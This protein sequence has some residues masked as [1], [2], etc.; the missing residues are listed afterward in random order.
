MAIDYSKKTKEELIQIIEEQKKQLSSTKYG[1]YWDKEIE[2]ENVVLEC[3]T[4]IPYL[5][6]IED[7][8]IFKNEN[9]PNNFIIEGD[10]FHALTC[11][12]MINKN[13]I[14]I[15]YI[16][17]PYNTGNETF[18]Y[19][20]NYVNLEDSFRHSK[21]LSFI[22]K[23]LILARE[24]LNDFGLIFI[25]IDDNELPNLLLL[26][27]QIFSEKNLI[28]IL[29]RV[30]K[31]GGKSTDTI[32]KNHDYVLVYAKNIDLI[33]FGRAEKEDNAKLEKDEF[34]EERGMYRLNQCLDYDSLQYNESMDYEINIDGSYFYA[35]GSK[36]LWESRHNGNHKKIDWVWRWSKGLLEW[37]LKNGFVVIK[38]GK[39]KRIYTKTYTNCVISKNENGYF[40]KKTENTKAYDSLYFTNNLFSNDNA[41]KELDSF[42]LSKKFD[43]PKPSSLIKECL[44]MGNNKKAVVLDFFAGSGTTGQAVLELNKEDG[45]ERK[46][47]LVTNNENEIFDKITYPRISTV[48]TGKK[49]DGS[50]YNESL[51]AN[52]ICYNCDFI[53][54][55][56]NDDQSLYNLVEKCNELL[57][58]KE[59][60]FIKEFSN[61]YYYIYR[62]FNKRL[63]IYFEFYNDNIITEM[64][65]KVNDSNLENVVYIFS[66]DNYIDEYT[67]KKFP[68]SKIKPIPSKIY[69]IYKEIVEDIKRGF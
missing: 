39:R 58:I 31:K 52:L 30:I 41:K 21:W 64:A 62:S 44:K 60:T 69:E 18:V 7:K 42:C 29:P 17:P 1:L 36:E 48:I 23:R 16:D 34:F 8:C 28:S 20:D 55:N 53:S 40:V 65:K 61:N 9:Y 6:R 50:L 27:N 24:L 63:F 37:G 38:N 3:K 66:A 25:S 46:F 35:G 11:L 57:C 59:D 49:I 13:S 5:K 51:N 12:N 10:N 4:K 19:S 67:I 22:N 56:N 2:E 47:I 54:D 14:D 33:N 26:C 15:I 43:Y 32:A 68:K 45:G